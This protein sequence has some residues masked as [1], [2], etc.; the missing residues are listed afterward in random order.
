MM[1]IQG[2]I[3]DL[4]GVLLDSMLIW[5][6]LGARYLKGRG[7]QPE[8]GLNQI[9]FS[10]SMEQGAEYLK[11]QYHLSDDLQEIV[12]DIEKM[13]QD[14]YFYEVQP[15]VGAK[16]LLEFLY[17]QDIKMVLATS[18]PRKLVTKALQRTNLMDYM[19]Q[20]FTTTEI[21][22]S[23]HSSLIYDIAASAL[24]TNPEETLVFED[25]YYAL[26]TAKDAGFKTVGV[27]DAYGESNQDEMCK[28]ADIYIKSLDE[29]KQYWTGVK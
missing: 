23:K 29:F 16:E 19:Q 18:S 3:F 13:I 12:N 20:I 14:F 4:D 17:Q 9:L 21:Q 28:T 15:K 2:A 6:D 24:G 25:S 1:G 22:E 11:T 26:K 5:N 27:Y 8:E 10:M 7:I